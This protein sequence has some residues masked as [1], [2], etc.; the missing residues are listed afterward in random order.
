MFEK[1]WVSE[2]V[3]F[4]LDILNLWW[5]LSLTFSA[6]PALEKLSQRRE[7]PECISVLSRDI[8]PFFLYKSESEILIKDGEERASNRV[9]N[10]YPY[11]SVSLIKNHFY[12][13]VQMNRPGIILKSRFQFNSS[14]WDLVFC[15]SKNSLVILE[16]AGPQIILRSKGLG[17][18]RIT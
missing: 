7:D 5:L 10:V 12:I 3:C 17:E 14:G 18:P 8:S 2:R 11:I 15:I 6:S 16:T 13:L 1:Y 4:L 9:L